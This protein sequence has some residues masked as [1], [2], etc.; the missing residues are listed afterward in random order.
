[1]AK[2]KTRT[3][4]DYTQPLTDQQINRVLDALDTSV[5]SKPKRRII[6]FSEPENGYYEFGQII[7]AETSAV[8]KKQFMA[9]I[10]AMGRTKAE[11][12]TDAQTFESLWQMFE[13]ALRRQFLGQTNFVE[14]TGNKI[15]PVFVTFLKRPTPNTSLKTRVGEISA[16]SLSGFETGLEGDANA[17]DN[18]HLLSC[19]GT[20]RAE[21]RRKFDA[22]RSLI[23]SDLSD[24]ACHQR[25]IQFLIGENPALVAQVK[26]Y[27]S[28]FMLRSFTTGEHPNKFYDFFPNAFLRQ[29]MT[30]LRENVYALGADTDPASVKGKAIAPAEVTAEVL[31]RGLNAY[32]DNLEGEVKTHNIP[33][34]TDKELAAFSKARVNAE[35]LTDEEKNL[36]LRPSQA[37]QLYFQRHLIEEGLKA[38]STIMPAAL[39]M[40]APSRDTGRHMDRLKTLQA[41]KAGLN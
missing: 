3:P 21:T 27:E 9:S 20:I 6:T 40:L 39:T 18:V 31:F 7:P 33:D 12:A 11:V 16:L 35:D 41:K 26:L 8:M 32:L 22:D 1:M 14:V 28:A 34:P 13:S 10:P 25:G 5:V 2:H 23:E 24:A 29:A 19:L 17:L 38:M 36:F 4:F 37:L 30:P 15:K